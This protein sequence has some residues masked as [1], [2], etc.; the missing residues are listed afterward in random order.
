[1]FRPILKFKKKN[2]NLK[3]NPP[4]TLKALLPVGRNSQNYFQN[5]VTKPLLKSLKEG[6]I[7]ST[8]NLIKK[9][10]SYKNEKYEKFLNLKRIKKKKN[11]RAHRLRNRLPLRGQRTHTNAKTRKVRNVQ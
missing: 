2:V 9:H 7:F 8:Y 11:Y 3:K 4:F 1:M 10:T 6:W 5:L